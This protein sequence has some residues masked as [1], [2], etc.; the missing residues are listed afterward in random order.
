VRV[1]FDGVLYNGRAASTD[2]VTGSVL[3]YLGALNRALASQ[4]SRQ[5][6]RQ[7]VAEEA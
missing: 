5:R 2:I 3:A 6:R 4:Q 7:A 1:E